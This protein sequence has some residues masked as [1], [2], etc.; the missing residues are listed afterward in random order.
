[1]PH[2]RLVMVSDMMKCDGLTFLWF[3]LI[4]VSDVLAPPVALA[5]EDSA[6][7]E[8]TDQQHT[9]HKDQNNMPQHENRLFFFK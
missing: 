3:G 6:N 5:E 2:D 1:M 7:E 9:T 4:D 8:T